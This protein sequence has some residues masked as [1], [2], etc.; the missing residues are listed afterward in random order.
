[1]GAHA[2][3]HV[4]GKAGP[5]PGSVARNR[6]SPYATFCPY[7]TFFEMKNVMYI[8]NKIVEELI[9]LCSKNPS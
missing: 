9:G 3:D 8:K 5:T 1:M 6:S 4:T 2:P 7:A